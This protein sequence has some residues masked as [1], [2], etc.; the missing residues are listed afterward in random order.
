VGSAKQRSF[1][2]FTGFDFGAFMT[3]DNKASKRTEANFAFSAFILAIFGWALVETQLF[4]AT[5]GVKA[6]LLASA[7][8]LVISAIA[9]RRCR[10]SWALLPDAPVGNRDHIGN[11]AS[12]AALAAAGCLFALAGKAG[13]I[14]LFVIYVGVFSFVP[15]SRIAFCRRYFF[16]SCAMLGVGAASILI[17]RGTAGPIIN[18]FY[19]W[20]LWSIA[21]SELLITSKR[22]R[23]AT[24][25][26]EQSSTVEPQSSKAGRDTLDTAMDRTG[27]SVL[28]GLGDQPR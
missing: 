15:W 3:T 16:V 1:N 27:E 12:C 11:V 26:P 17:A 20:V 28:S 23:P 6:H 2:R 10:R 14:T 24:S 19:A 21:L 8:G 22:D 13:S 7:F 4:S 9:L 5:T 25:R 18:L